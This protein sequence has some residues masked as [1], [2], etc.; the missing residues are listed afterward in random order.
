MEFFVKDDTR[1]QMWKTTTDKVE[2]LTKLVRDVLQQESRSTTQALHHDV[3]VVNNPLR[4]NIRQAPLASI[5]D[6]VRN[7]LDDKDE[8]GVLQRV[9]LLVT[10]AVFVQHV[11][12]GMQG[13]H[14]PTYRRHE[15]AILHD[16]VDDDRLNPQGS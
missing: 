1:Y 10:V 6:A 12:Q 7:A 2:V 8:I 9:V 5:A 14:V 16:N 15:Q 13:M 4:H 11:V 3:G